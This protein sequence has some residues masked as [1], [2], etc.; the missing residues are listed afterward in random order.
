MIFEP[1]VRRARFS[2]RVEHR[3]LGKALADIGKR[4]ART[5]IPLVEQ[6]LLRQFHIAGAPPGHHCAT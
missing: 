5:P 4:F 3:V 2:S 1:G 6:V